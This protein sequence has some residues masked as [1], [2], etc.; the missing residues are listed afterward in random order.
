MPGNIPVNTN[1]IYCF[2]ASC[3]CFKKLK[4]SHFTHQRW[5]AA[6]IKSRLVVCSPGSADPFL[7]QSQH[8]L[9]S[10][11]RK[12]NCWVKW[13]RLSCCCSARVSCGNLKSLVIRVS[14]LSKQVYFRATGPAQGFYLLNCNL[15]LGL[16]WLTRDTVD[17]LLVYIITTDENLFIPFKTESKSA[18]PP[19]RLRNVPP[20]PTHL[21]SLQAR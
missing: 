4:D 5:N 7:G 9:W 20:S 18:P 11:Q 12:H 2:T 15:S 17:A 13:L 1:T 14:S 6:A 21:Q 10:C 19:L 16:C 8:T 3:G